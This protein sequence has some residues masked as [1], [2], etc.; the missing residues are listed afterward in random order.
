MWVCALQHQKLFFFSAMS[1]GSCFFLPHGARIYNRLIDFI[2]V[3][4]PMASVAV[5][6]S[7]LREKTKANILD[8][9]TSTLL[10]SDRFGRFLPLLIAPLILCFLLQLCT[11]FALAHL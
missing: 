7:G 5:R 4:P 10:Q 6:H 1:P 11:L 3:S 8:S 9:S 2:R